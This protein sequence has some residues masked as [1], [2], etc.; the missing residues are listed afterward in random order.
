[1]MPLLYA[2]PGKELIITKIIGGKNLRNKLSSMS[3]IPGKE[4]NV[5]RPA[6]NNSTIIRVDNCR[7]AIGRGIAMR[8]FVKIKEGKGNNENQ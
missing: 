8:I 7:Y 2:S 4:I 1:M 6:C 5:I 3:L